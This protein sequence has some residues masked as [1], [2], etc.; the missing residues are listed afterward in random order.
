MQIINRTTLVIERDTLYR[1]IIINA[2]F[3]NSL[4]YLYPYNYKPYII[5]DI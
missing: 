4:M 2:V 1:N 5:D 3:L